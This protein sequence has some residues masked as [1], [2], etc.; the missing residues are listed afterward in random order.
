MLRL[1]N[2]RDGTKA[3]KVSGLNCA[4]RRQDELTGKNEVRERK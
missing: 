4:W 2:K 3:A 1:V